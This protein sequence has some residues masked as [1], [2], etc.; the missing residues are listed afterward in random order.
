MRSKNN[1][2]VVDVVKESALNCK[3]ADSFGGEM[4][5]EKNVKMSKCQCGIAELDYNIPEL[6]RDNKYLNS[7]VP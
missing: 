1:I 6:E 3:I 4:S 7:F 2:P 5:Y